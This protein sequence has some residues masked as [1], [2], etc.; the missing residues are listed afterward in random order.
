MSNGVENLSQFLDT[1]GSGGTEGAIKWVANWFSQN[2]S[3]TPL[4]ITSKLDQGKALS[5]YGGWLNYHFKI[6]TAFIL[7]GKVTQEVN[8]KMVE[9]KISPAS[10]MKS[11]IQNR[12]EQVREILLSDDKDTFMEE[13][14]G[15]EAE[16]ISTSA[17]EADLASKRGDDT[18]AKVKR[19]SSTLD[20]I[21][22]SGNYFREETI[23]LLEAQ[24]AR[25]ESILGMVKPATE[26]VA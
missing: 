12:H 21:T 13:F 3:I 17:S 9:T 18:H 24:K 20:G 7:G 11:V 10:A 4:Q 8:G 16:F 19:I 23:A 14:R 5:L 26:K 2:P 25:I 6:D 22:P 15:I 1:R